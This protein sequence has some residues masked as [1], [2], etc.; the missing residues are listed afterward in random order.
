MITQTAKS[1]AESQ[2]GHR[3]ARDAVR[4]WE[5]IY[6]DQMREDIKPCPEKGP[7]SMETVDKRVRLDVDA[8]KAVKE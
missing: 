8:G 7:V 5:P 4:K 6:A 1:E 2:S 3:G